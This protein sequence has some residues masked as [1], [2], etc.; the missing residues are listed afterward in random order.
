MGWWVGLFDYSVKQGPDLSRSGLGL[1]RLVTRSAK[2]RI[3][4]VGDQVSQV[5]DQ[6]GFL[7]RTDLMEKQ[8][9]LLQ[10]QAQGG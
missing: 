1:V 3:G 6:V 7:C 10:G 8:D 5:K 2:A 4:Q 9:C